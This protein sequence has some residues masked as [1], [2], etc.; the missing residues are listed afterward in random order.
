[1]SHLSRRQ[2]LLGTVGACL[3]AN[4]AQPESAVQIVPLPEAGIQPQ[5]MLSGGTVHLVYFRGNPRHGDVFY[6][7]SV[8][9]GRTFSQ[10]IRVNSQP[11]SAIAIGTIRGAQI[12]VGRNGRVHVAWNGSDLAE[13]RGPLNPEAGKAGAPMLYSRLNDR[14]TSFDPQRNLMSRTFGLDGGGSV[15]A[16]AAGN[17]YVAWHGKMAGAPVGEAGRRVWIASSRSDGSTFTEEIPASDK[18]AGACGCC[19]LRL[20]VDARGAVYCL[21]R[22]ARQNVH[23]DIYLLRSSDHGRTFSQSLL[24]PW[25]INA[26]PMSSMAFTEAGSEVLSAWETSSQVYFAP[27]S[28]V[29]AVSE[30]KIVHPS[31]ENFKR[32]YPVI[33]ANRSQIMLAWVEGAGWQRAGT[34]GWQLFD[35]DGQPAASIGSQQVVVPVWS[36][37]AVIARPDGGFTVIV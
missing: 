3:R 36:F 16:D 15:G 13:P 17:V 28:R 7:R 14:G 37:P 4:S 31:G 30:S 12:A 24:H 34:L 11:G 33:A 9:F 22:S 35:S 1:M 32:K 25:K 23:R 10:E 5:A 29:G 21:Y 19:G 6:A 26:C 20:F 18:A 8:D 27:V 2:L